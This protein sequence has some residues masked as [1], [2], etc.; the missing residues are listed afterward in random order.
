[1]HGIGSHVAENVLH[2]H[3]VA[4][5]GCSLH[6]AAYLWLLSKERLEEA[7]KYI[8]IKHLLWTLNLLKTDD[9]EHVIAS[10]WKCDEKTFRKWLYVVLNVISD[11][12]V[13]SQHL[14]ALRCAA[15]YSYSLYSLL[16]LLLLLLFFFLSKIDWNCRLDVPSHCNVHVTID[17]TDFR[18]KEQYPFSA[19][20][21][22]QKTLFLV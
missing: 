1:M 13:V 14:F 6:T 20:W 3:W 18:I 11:L 5:F 2:R 21:Y 15:L 7:D 12:G 22:S 4:S 8:E 16:L 19:S 17:G 10:R 9:K